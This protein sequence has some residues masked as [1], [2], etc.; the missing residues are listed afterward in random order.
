MAFG[1]ITVTNELMRSCNRKI[2]VTSTWLS[3]QV[4]SKKREG[5][6]INW[7][8][9]EKNRGRILVGIEEWTW[10]VQAAHQ[11]CCTHQP[12]MHLQFVFINGGDEQFHGYGTC[13]STNPSHSN[14]QLLPFLLFQC[15]THQGSTIWYIVK[16]SSYWELGLAHRTVFFFTTSLCHYWIMGRSIHHTL[17]YFQ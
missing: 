14:T 11:T 9:E 16:S 4:A 15:N 5:K 2:T 13:V 12:Q 8:G 7:F 1:Q 17:L 6:R 10:C 3:Q